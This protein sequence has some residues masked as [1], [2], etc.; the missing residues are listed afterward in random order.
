MTTVINVVAC[1]NNEKEV[2]VRIL[3]NDGV[4]ETFTLQ[5]G[6]NIETHVYD[7][8]KI[9]VQEVLIND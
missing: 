8:R 7:D 1:C 3:D 2:L 9:T 5:N 6:E 4:V